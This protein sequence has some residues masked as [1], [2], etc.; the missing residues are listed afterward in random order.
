MLPDSAI[1]ARIAS[2]RSSQIVQPTALA[3][4]PSRTKAAHQSC[5]SGMDSRAARAASAEAGATRPGGTVGTFSDILA[6]TRRRLLAVAAKYAGTL[7]NFRLRSWVNRSPT[8]TFQSDGRLDWRGS[9][10]VT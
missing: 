2:D 8:E 10:G 5:R 4:T 9:Y 1:A 7:P 6:V 3:E